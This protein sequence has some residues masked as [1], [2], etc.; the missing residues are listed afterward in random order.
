MENDG[1]SLMGRVGVSVWDE[2]GRLC[3]RNHKENLVV[4]D[5]FN[6]AAALIAK[7]SVTE[8]THMAAGNS[9]TA[10][11]ESQSDLQ[12][13][14]LARVSVNTSRIGNEITHTA[15]FSGINSDITVSE[16]GL[17]ND[18]SAGTMFA[19]F[20]YSTFTLYAGQSMEIDWTIRV[21]Q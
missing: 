5:G 8:V 2:R 11:D 19:R 6:L 16:F 7:E 15:D 10:E 4:V 18:S 14:E 9:S 1:I 12:G 3:W 13:T 17:F 20:T 21:G